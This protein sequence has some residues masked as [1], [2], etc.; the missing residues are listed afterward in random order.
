MTHT[1]E[2]PIEKQG[3]GVPFLRPPRCPESVH[4]ARVNR[5]HPILTDVDPN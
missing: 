1:Q 5:A 4:L 3:Y 2:Q